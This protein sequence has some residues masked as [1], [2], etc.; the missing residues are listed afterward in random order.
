M[1]I[2]AIGP[3]STG[4]PSAA[5]SFKVGMPGQKQPTHTVEGMSDRGRIY[6]DHG[7]KVLDSDVRFSRAELLVIEK[8]LND[9]KKKKKQQHL[10][11]VKEIV[12]NKS[13]R[14]RLLK[15]ALVHA[16]GAY[17][18]EQKRVY[19]FDDLSPEEIPEV[20]IHEIGHAVNHF[21]LSFARFMEF[22]QDTGWNMTEMRRV[23]FNDNKLYQFGIKPVEVPKEKWDSV[24]DRFSLNSLSKEQDVFGEILIELPKKSEAPWDKNPLEKFAWSYEWFYNKNKAFKKI[25]EKAYREKGDPSLKK[26]YEFMQNEVFEE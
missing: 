8:V 2:S 6:K 19:L 3:Y 11:G 18:A 22:I 13:V 20:L 4:A 14:V 24:W 5:L 25:A 26:A 10:L 17:V 21:N 7:V 15:N 9:L 1:S 12:K 23:F 16:G